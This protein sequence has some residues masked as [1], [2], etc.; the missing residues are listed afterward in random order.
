M[1]SIPLFLLIKETNIL[2]QSDIQEH[3]N[4]CKLFSMAQTSYEKKL[5]DSKS[6]N[7]KNIHKKEKDLS[8]KVWSWFE[9]LSIEEKLKICTIKNNWVIRILIQL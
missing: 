2:S 3:Q 9:N 5:E 8:T 6:K 7:G 4:F 1:Y